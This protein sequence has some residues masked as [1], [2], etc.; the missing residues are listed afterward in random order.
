MHHYYILNSDPRAYEVFDF[1]A[2]HKIACEVHLNRTRF[3]VPSGAVYTEF[4]L[5]FSDC[6]HYVDPALDLTTGMPD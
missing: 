1:I 2:H 3:W 5:R 4:V 6:A